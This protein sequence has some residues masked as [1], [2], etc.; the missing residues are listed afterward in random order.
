MSQKGGS[1][2]TRPIENR[3]RL[4][5]PSREAVNWGRSTG[6]EM[7][8]HFAMRQLRRN[9]HALVRSGCAHDERYGPTARAPGDI[10]TKESSPCAMSASAGL[11]MIAATEKNACF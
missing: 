4:A 5:G 8:S 11:R 3:R 10:I 6:R 7:L 1:R 2:G 9:S